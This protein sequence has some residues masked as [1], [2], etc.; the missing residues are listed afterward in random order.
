MQQIITVMT[1]VVAILAIIV[2]LCQLKKNKTTNEGQSFSLVLTALM[3]AISIILAQF[4]FYIPLFGF[5]SLRFSVTGIPIFI[6]G[7]FL[8]PLYGAM[9][10]FTS[11]II[12]FMMTSTGTYHF[13][14]TL[15]SMLV[16]TMPGIIF[17]LIRTGRIKGQFGK[18][19]KVLGGVALL[20]A[21]IYINSIGLKE[22]DE[23]GMI[24]PVPV[25]I[26]LSG[27]MILLVIG[28]MFMIHK[29]KQ[30]YKGDRG[31]YSIDQIIFIKC[32]SYIVL[33]LV[34][35][36]IWMLQ[37]YNIPIFASVT[38][39]IFKSLIDVPLQV[40]I[41]YTVIHAIPVKM[42]EKLV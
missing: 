9:A 32:I 12:G 28:L 14:F 26:V 5:P 23:V 40:I 4:Q 15:N 22:L 7:A 42:R 2:L 8:G 34:L 33:Q 6:V 35:T 25:N 31:L 29:L 21:L 20:G 18:A 39:R 19:N 10:G 11:D 3:V 24:G 27:L 16:G 17:H 41:I 37:M 38:V 36:P 30:I 1:F 13:G